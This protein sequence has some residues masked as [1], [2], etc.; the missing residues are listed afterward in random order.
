MFRELH[1][2]ATKTVRRSSH[3]VQVEDGPLFAAT[4]ATPGLRKFIKSSCCYAC[5]FR[6]RLRLWLRLPSSLKLRRT[7]VAFLKDFI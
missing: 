3:E 6:L 1:F 4:A 2:K 5:G 7:Y